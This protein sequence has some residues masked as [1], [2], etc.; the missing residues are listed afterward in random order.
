M[1]RYIYKNFIGAC[2]A[3]S[4]IMLNVFSANAQ[5]TGNCPGADF[6]TGTF[7]PE[8]QGY[9]GTCCPINTPTVGIDITPPYQHAILASPA[10]I[11]PRT[12]GGLNITPAFVGGY[13]CKLGNEQTGA[14]AERLVYTMTV[15]ASNALFV[16]RYAVVLQDPGHFPAE[17]PRFEISVLN[18]ADSLIDP[19]C[20]YYNVV[21]SANIPG[22][23]LCSVNQTVWKDWTTVGIS[24]VSYINQ[25]INIQFQTGDCDLTGHYG[26]AYIDCYCMPMAITTEFC[27]GANQVILT[28][29]PGFTSYQW[30][31]GPTTQIDT[32]NNPTVGQ[33][34]TV[35]LT[36][37]QNCLLAITTTL[38]STVMTP[39]F[40]A[41]S[42]PCDLNYTFQD[43]STIVN[44]QFAHWSWDFGDASPLDTNQNT[45]HAYLTPGSYIVWH[46]TYSV[47]GCADSVMQVIN[48]AAPP[49]ADFSSDTVCEG[50]T[51]TFTDLSTVVNDN[52]TT[53]AWDFG[54]LSTD[55]SQNPQHA[56]AAPG[57]YVVSLVVTSSSGCVD[58]IS[59]TVIVNAN[60]VIQTLGLPEACL[61]DSAQL[62]AIGGVMYTWAPCIALSS[63]NGSPV[64][65]APDTTTIYTVTGTDANGCSSTATSTVI[66]HLLPLVVTPP[67]PAYCDGGSTTVTVSGASTYSWSP[68]TG[69]SNPSSDSATVTITLNQTTTYTVVG[70]SAEGCTAST[71]F[72][73]TVH[74]LPVATISPDG[75]LAFCDGGDVD[76]TG[77]PNGMT[78]YTWSN[79]SLAQTINVIAS[80]TF[81]VT[82]VDTNG[83]SDVSDPVTVT[84]NPNPVA[85]ISPPNPSVCANS[86]IVLTASGGTTFLW[87]TGDSTASITA[88]DGPY[89]VTVWDV[90]NCSN[91]TSITVALNPGITAGV[92]PVGPV[93][94]CT[95]NPAILT[96]NPS[97]PGY[98]FQWYEAST[99]PILNATSDTYTANVNGSYSVI[100]TDPNGCT[101]SSNVVL[102]TLGQGPTVTI[103]ATPTI[104]CL[105]NT[106][107]IGY[108]PQTI[109]LTAVASAGAVHY[110]WFS[111][112]IPMVGDTNQTLQVS[113]SGTYSVL[114]YDANWCPSPQPAVL[115]PAINVIDIRCGH[116]LK[117]ILLCHVPEGNPGN[118]QTLCIGPPA[119][120]PHL[121]LHRYDCLGPCSLYYRED[122]MIEVDNFYV[123]PHPNPFSTGFSISILSSENSPVR[124]NVL[125]VL[126]QIVETHNNVTEQTIMGAALSR[127]IYFAEVIQGNNRQMIQVVKSE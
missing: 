121:E 83:C 97:G 114:A 94:I 119:I 6:E 86:T 72:T 30:S 91:S 3:A 5:S 103:V 84:V 93:S 117:K 62:A 18:A 1:T 48:I 101:G 112:S 108:G 113:T 67:A 71:T 80:G 85:V 127:G 37:V 60:P 21:A 56:Y 29:P 79:L 64:M 44:G 47:S 109:T 24:L 124:V 81:T 87:S 2:F 16:Y 28:A 13:V 20:G 17:Q 65:A 26:Y 68:T 43:T 89:S 49:V 51:T 92:T 61:G 105:L 111:N 69:I 59:H 100:I 4:L 31:N 90:N 106:I 34:V 107:Y 78:S 14:Q 88:T 9:T 77:M 41:T 54:D 126:G 33:Q 36:T 23:N 116:G 75:P 40:S 22:F 122:D 55:V 11:D 125:D 120:P 50:G 38:N 118:P 57:T 96:A 102:V 10:G 70:H 115:T 45:T 123:L 52:I 95:G 27:I 104:G 42:A 39:G 15:D 82:V 19:I 63:C 66:I 76:L 73:V 46:H 35:V 7:T 25:T 74:P 12:C 32:V 99:G 53:W 110:Q 8:W 98:F 58:S